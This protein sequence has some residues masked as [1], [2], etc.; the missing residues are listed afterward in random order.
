MSA[1]NEKKIEHGRQKPL[2]LI[3]EIRSVT[4][5]I[6]LEK[7]KKAQWNLCGSLNGKK[8]SPLE[9]EVT[10]GVKERVVDYLKSK[11]KSLFE[12]HSDF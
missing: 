11:I 3:M 5:S 8:V 9:I 4:A 10:K 7:S 12:K 2:E 6:S 1:I